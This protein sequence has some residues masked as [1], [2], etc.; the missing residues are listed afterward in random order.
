MRKRAYIGAATTADTKTH[1]RPL[2]AAPE[3]LRPRLQYVV[4]AEIALHE[5]NSLLQNAVQC[6][7]VDHLSAVNI[8]L[9]DRHSL[10]RHNWWTIATF[11]RPGK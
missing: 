1:R 10:H 4:L 5:R 2:T 9:S 8:N 7:S 11:A 3:Q 6:I